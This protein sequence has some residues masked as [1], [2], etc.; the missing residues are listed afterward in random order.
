MLEAFPALVKLADCRTWKSKLKRK[1]LPDWT[2][3]Q[4]VE[5]FA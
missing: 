5:E 2:F 3:I 4:L 1:S